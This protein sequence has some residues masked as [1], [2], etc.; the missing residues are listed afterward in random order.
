MEFLCDFVFYSNTLTIQDKPLG[1]LNANGYYDAILD[2]I[3]MAIQEGFVSASALSKL[4]VE[5]ELVP[6]L[7]RIAAWKP[8]P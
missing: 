1:V 7:D 2:W 4:I 8:S 3:K 6:L 5:T